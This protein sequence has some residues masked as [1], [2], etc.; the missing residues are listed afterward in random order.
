MSRLHELAERMG[1]DVISERFHRRIEKTSECWN[2]TGG[3]SER[4]YGRM[5]IGRKPVPAHRVS[6]FLET[7]LWPPDG[8]DVCHHCDNPSCVRPDHLFVGSRS[9][10]MKD[11]SKKGRINFAGLEA[12]R[13]RKTHCR[14]G[15]ALEGDN[16]KIRP[17]DRLCRQCVKITEL[18]RLERAEL[19]SRHIGER[20]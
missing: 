14:R 9:E 4:G 6:L 18:R 10:N 12:G 5:H 19:A 17:K 16:L 3:K 8:K 13:H 15:H 2:W 7:G 20:E 11:A 1:R